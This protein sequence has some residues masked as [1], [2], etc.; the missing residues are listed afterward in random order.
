MDTI[1]GGLRSV[2]ENLKNLYLSAFVHLYILVQHVLSF[3][4]A[5]SPPAPPTQH[6]QQDGGTQLRRPRIAIIGAGLTGVSAASH[7]V[8]HGFEVKIFESRSKGKGLGG[9]WSVR[10]DRCFLCFPGLCIRI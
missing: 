8:G 7:C 5:P 10:R 6:Q 1:Q 2:T 3:I 9:I 4:F